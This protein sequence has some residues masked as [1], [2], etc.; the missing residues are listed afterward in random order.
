MSSNSRSVS[1]DCTHGQTTN[2]E[3]LNYTYRL[4]ASVRRQRL[5]GRRVVT[6]DIVGTRELVRRAGGFQLRG[7]RGERRR[8]TTLTPR[9]LGAECDSVAGAMGQ[10]GQ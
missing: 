5:G 7:G 2:A 10:G 1:G 4:G 3:R 8:G 6:A 9:S